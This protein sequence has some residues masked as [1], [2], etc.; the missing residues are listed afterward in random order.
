MRNSLLSILL[1][2]LILSGCG[3]DSI[4]SSVNNR[5]SRPEIIQPTINVS[6]V[7]PLA[8]GTEVKDI[9]YLKKS[10]LLI[11]R[12]LATFK[13]LEADLTGFEEKQLITQ[14]KNLFKDKYLITQSDLIEI[15]RNLNEALSIRN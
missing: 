9:E 4:S 3:G 2:S 8:S 11:R 10:F 7:R 13:A 15:K 12:I 5:P 6:T 1:L 14:V